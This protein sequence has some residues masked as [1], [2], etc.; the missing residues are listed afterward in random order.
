MAQWVKNLTWCPWGCKFNPWPRPVGSASSVAAN[1]GIGCRCGS[2]LVLLWLWCWP[3]AP[4]WLL[5]WE[6]PH[7]CGPKNK[8]GK[9]R[10]NIGDFIHVNAE[11]FDSSI[12]QPRVF[13]FWGA[14]RPWFI[15]HYF[16]LR[17]PFLF[18]EG[19][20]SDPCSTGPLLH[21]LEQNIPLPFPIHILG[22]SNSSTQSSQPENP[23]SP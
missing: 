4:V 22:N 12:W 20:G 18:L 6:L 9:K 5:A 13:F 7:R 16:F 19:G 3:A 23:L 17:V 11:K 1:G 2:A 14:C 10:S 15:F 8:K 21:D